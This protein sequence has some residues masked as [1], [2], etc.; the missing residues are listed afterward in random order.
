MF[1]RSRI[2]F[3]LAVLAGALLTV[4]PS[5]G[6]GAKKG[7]TKN[8]T[9]KTADGVELSGTLYPA[10]SGK[11]DATVIMLHSFDLKK[12]GSSSSEEGWGQLAASL[13]AAGYVVLTFDFRGFGESKTL[14]NKNEFVNARTP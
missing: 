9:F 14:G 8:V 5:H 12:G 7:N 1:S 4:G 6:Q 10:P 13:Q 3:G 11:R 2:L